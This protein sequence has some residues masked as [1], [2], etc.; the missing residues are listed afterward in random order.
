MK[1][2]CLIDPDQF[3]NHD[4]DRA[5]LFS[6]RVCLINFNQSLVEKKKTRFDCEK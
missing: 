1:N 2:Q 3:F 5:E 4:R 6:I